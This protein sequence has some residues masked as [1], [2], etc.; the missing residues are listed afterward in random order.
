MDPVCPL[1]RE[2]LFQGANDQVYRCNVC[3]F[4]IPAGYLAQ[5]V[6]TIRNPRVRYAV[7]MGPRAP[8][9]ESAARSRVISFE[10]ED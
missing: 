9:P 6:D 2:R 10:E 3:L 5:Y 8:K 1:C 4:E 7:R